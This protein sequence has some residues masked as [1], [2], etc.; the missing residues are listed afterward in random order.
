MTVIARYLSRQFADDLNTQP[1]ADF[2]VVDLLV[3]EQLSKHWRVMLDAEN[4]T[5]RAHVATQTG[6]L[7]TLGAFML[8]PGIPSGILIMHLSFVRSRL[9]QVPLS[10]S[11][12][13]LFRLLGLS[14]DP[15]KRKMQIIL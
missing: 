15:E 2:V 4:L 1:I 10:P 8:I 7:L 12:L 9:R 5:D 11:L 3:Q 14:P 6:S 13:D